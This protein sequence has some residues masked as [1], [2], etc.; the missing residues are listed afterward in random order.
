MF[1]HLTLQDYIDKLGL[2]NGG[3]V[4]VSLGLPSN[5]RDLAAFLDY[6]RGFLNRVPDASNLRPR[7]RC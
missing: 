4:R 7:E 2:R 1:E 6:L 5:R 3:A